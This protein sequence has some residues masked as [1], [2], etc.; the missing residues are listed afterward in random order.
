MYVAAQ[1]LLDW[2]DLDADP[3][4]D[5]YQYACGGFLANSTIA[6]DANGDLEFAVAKNITNFIS[7][8]PYI[9]DGYKLT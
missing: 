8:L 7:T 5:F 9:V 6:P 4:E 2:M 1:R 3:C